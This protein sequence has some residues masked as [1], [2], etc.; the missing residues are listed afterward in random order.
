[1]KSFILQYQQAVPTVPVSFTSASIHGTDYYLPTPEK[2]H[3]AMHR[4]LRHRCVLSCFKPRC[5]S[6][7]TC[8]SFQNTRH[9][10]CNTQG[11]LR[12]KAS[13]FPCLT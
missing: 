4:G 7:Q 13:S 3:S 9:Q 10:N 2:E 12:N 8:R 1:L 11:A 6:A 5:R